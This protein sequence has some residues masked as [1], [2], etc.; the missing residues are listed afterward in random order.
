MN[1]K[2]A[3]TFVW[4]AVISILLGMV[5]M[6]PA[7]SLSLYSIAALFAAIPAIFSTKRTRIAAIVILAVSL[8]LLAVTYPKFDAEITKYRE[9]AHKK[10]SEVSTPQQEAGGNK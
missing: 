6:S 4:A 7:G 8:V 3:K 1:P 10:S 9:R 2:S 5:V